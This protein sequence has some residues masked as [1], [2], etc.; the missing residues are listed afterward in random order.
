MPNWQPT[1]ILLVA[2]LF[3][4]MACRDSKPAPFLIEVDIRPSSNAP[5]GISFSV[6]G[7]ETSRI[8][9]G[10]YTSLEAACSHLHEEPLLVE[11]HDVDGS[12]CGTSEV[13]GVC[14][15]APEV[16]SSPVVKGTLYVSFAGDGTS[17]TT[18]GNCD[19]VDG[20]SVH[21]DEG[22]PDAGSS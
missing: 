4:T 5:E 21:G 7:E 16:L 13:F 19:A 17:D 11:C 18:E 12:T 3:A 14:C 2:A 10:N 6:N 22:V 9:H 1:R 8:W 20:S 15:W